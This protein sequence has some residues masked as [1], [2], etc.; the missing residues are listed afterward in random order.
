MTR[1]YNSFAHLLDGVYRFSAANAPAALGQGPRVTIAGG[2]HGNE[3]IGVKVLDALRLALFEVALPS[4]G[5]SGSSVLASGCV[6]LVY[7]N[8]AALRIGKRGSSPHEDLN[9]CFS[10]DSLSTWRETDA[11]EHHRARELEPILASSDVLIDLHSTNKPS[12]PFVRIAGHTQGVPRPMLQIAARLPCD[13][14]L[15]DPRFLIAGGKVALMDEYVGASG[16]LGICF[17]SG[18][19]SDLSPSKIKRMTSSIWKILKHE[20]QSL[21]ANALAPEADVEKFMTYEVTQ[22]FKLT[23]Q[24]FEWAAGVGDANFQLVP[25]R[26]PIGFIGPDRKPFAVDYDAYIVFPKIP[27]LWKIGA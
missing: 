27:S 18:L 26:Q 13:I 5:M 10:K 17:E 1:P 8:P 23:E 14:L 16:G 21:K 19:A 11:Y 20:T 4:P 15:H 24:G 3:R 6:T 12:P 25:A 2:V 9:R 7:G 22:V